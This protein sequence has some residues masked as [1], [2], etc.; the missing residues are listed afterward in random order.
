MRRG[1]AAKATVDTGSIPER[2]NISNAADIESGLAAYPRA[3]VRG[4][5]GAAAGRATH[6]S[7]SGC[8]ESVVGPGD[9]LQS[10]GASAPRIRQNDPRF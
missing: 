6:P 7:V 10:A 1:H 2:G 8:S 5:P 3:S 9:K 4:L